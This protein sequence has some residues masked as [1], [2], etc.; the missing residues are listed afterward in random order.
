MRVEKTA[1]PQAMPFLRFLLCFSGPE[2][3]G[4]I[5]HGLGYLD[6]LR[7]DGLAAAAADAGGGLDRKSVV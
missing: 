2:A 4:E 1:W 3:L 5:G 6:L 7:T